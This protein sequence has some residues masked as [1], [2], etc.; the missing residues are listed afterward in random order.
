MKAS[1]V[2][3]FVQIQEISSSSETWPERSLYLQQFSL[4]P[5]QHC[6]IPS[7]PWVAWADCGIS[8]SS[9]HLVPGLF[10]TANTVRESCFTSDFAQTGFILFIV[11]RY[12]C[13]K[14]TK[15]VLK[16]SFAARCYKSAA[17]TST[18]PYF[19]TSVLTQVSLKGSHFPFWK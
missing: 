9:L 18:L 11:A 10:Y 2:P 15:H 16:C 19:K 14:H 3:V 6:G 8:Q 4:F 1:P 13:L 12:L 7:P 17:A 5:W